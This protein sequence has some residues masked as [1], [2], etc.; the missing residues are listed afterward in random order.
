MNLVVFY[1]VM[2][3]WSV[4]LQVATESS[5]DATWSEVWRELVRRPAQ[6]RLPRATAHTRTS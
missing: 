4:I 1:L 2:V 3:A 5:P 6:H